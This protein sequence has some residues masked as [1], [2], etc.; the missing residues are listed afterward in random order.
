MFFWKAVSVE[1]HLGACSSTVD[2]L[3]EAAVQG[4]PTRRS[5]SG[6][7]SPEDRVEEQD[8]VC[9]RGGEFP[10]SVPAVGTRSPQAR[11]CVSSP[12]VVFGA[13]VFISR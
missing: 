4:K 7:T 5:W 12:A 9:H 10:S 1:Q 2:P 3:R 8:T 11:R 6:E 13:V